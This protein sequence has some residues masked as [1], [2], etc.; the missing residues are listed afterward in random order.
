MSIVFSKNSVE[1]AIRA[2]NDETGRFLTDRFFLFVHTN[3]TVKML[4]ILY[5]HCCGLI[6]HLCSHCYRGH[7]YC[8]ARCRTA[9]RRQA[10]REAQRRYRNTKK[11]KD[12]H[13]EYERQRR[14]GK[15]KGKTR[16]RVFPVLVKCCKSAVE[17]AR[18]I[19]EAGINL[20]DEALCHFCRRCGTIVDQFQRS[21]AKVT[22]EP[23][24]DLT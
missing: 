9:A 18:S 19:I 15:S 10:R 21:S 11:G 17:Q 6:F 13:R 24:K 20:G 3:E 2:G 12:Y 23:A 5:C 16:S 22:T 8:S 1:K 4:I 14:M 7:R